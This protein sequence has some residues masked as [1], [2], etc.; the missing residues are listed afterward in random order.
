[1]EHRG[2]SRRQVGVAAG[3]EPDCVAV[4]DGLD[5]FAADVEAGGDLVSGWIDAGEARARDGRIAT[6]ATTTC[7]GV[8]MVEMTPFNARLLG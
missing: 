5:D 2:G 6:L 8:P 3:D 7:A 4:G 1:M